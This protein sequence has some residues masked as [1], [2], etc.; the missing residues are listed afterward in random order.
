[1]GYILTTSQE[2]I[3]HK[4]PYKKAKQ[5]PYYGSI[6]IKK[7]GVGILLIIIEP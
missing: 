3:L 2:Y 6:I 5:E 7:G 1:M 4:R